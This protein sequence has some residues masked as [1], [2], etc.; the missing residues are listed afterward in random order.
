MKIL[1]T[2]RGWSLLLSRCLGLWMEEIATPTDEVL[3]G[4]LRQLLRSWARSERLG[5]LLDGVRP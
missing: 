4:V 2:W 3:G 5:E 1:S